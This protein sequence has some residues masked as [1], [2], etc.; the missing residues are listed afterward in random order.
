MARKGKGDSAKA[1][2]T[3]TPATG[4]MVATA[5]PAA[6]EESEGQEPKDDES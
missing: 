1:P 3:S 5:A 4:E 2:L 6:P